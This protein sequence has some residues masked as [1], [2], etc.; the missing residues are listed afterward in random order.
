MNKSMGDIKEILLVV[1]PISGDIN[2]KN[3]VDELKI[4]I[5]S[6]GA[7][8]FIY[9]TKGKNDLENIRK[10]T[11]E[12]QP[13][14]IITA[15][16]DGTIK[17]VAEAT[18][19]FN[20]PMGIIPGGSAN[21]LA[22]NLKIP[23]T[24][25]EQIDV[26]LGTNFIDID[27]ICLNNEIGLHMSDLGINAELIKNYEESTFRG[28]FGY[29]LQTVPTLIKGKYPYSFTIETENEKIT[30]KGILLA[31]ANA[32]K[33]GT[34]ANVNPNGKIDDGIMEILIFKDFD[35]REILNTLRN[36]TNLSKDFVKVIPVKEA[37]V[38]CEEP[39]PFQ[40]DGEYLGEVTRV[41]VNILSE[42]AK[43]AVPN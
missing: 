16:G 36:E 14:R 15:G 43:I 17:L 24:L 25:E 33:Y 27:L 1:N 34:G 4:I 13:S 31:F 2:K 29:L 6:K 18:K 12:R 7:E 30:E 39:V 41:N 9:H 32:Q 8:L 38:T 20:I 26:A 40:I 21:A 23:D 22:L 3:M 11:E 5:E 35:F 10:I 28:K 37:K 42:K 19:S